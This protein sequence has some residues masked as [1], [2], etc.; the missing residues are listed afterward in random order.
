MVSGDMQWGQNCYRHYG[1]Q[2]LVIF[3]RKFWNLVVVEWEIYFIS[4][5]VKIYTWVTN[6]F[7]RG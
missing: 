7:R 5:I 6:K 2:N 4:E 3:A 1:F